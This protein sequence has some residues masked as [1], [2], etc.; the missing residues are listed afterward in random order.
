M[1]FVSKTSFSSLNDLYRTTDFFYKGSSGSVL[2]S[3]VSTPNDD[4]VKEAIEKYKLEKTNAVN[5]TESLNWYID[6]IGIAISDTQTFFGE[7]PSALGG[8]ISQLQ[9]LQSVLQEMKRHFSD[10]ETSTCAEKVFIVEQQHKWISAQ[11]TGVAATARGGFTDIP[12]EERVTAAE[13]LVTDVGIDTGSDISLLTLPRDFKEQC[14]FLS[15]IFQ[16]TEFHRD[17]QGGALSESTVD[18]T[19]VEARMSINAI[20]GAGTGNAENITLKNLPYAADRDWEIP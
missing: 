13:N 11:E 16:F 8:Q 7:E 3:Q 14:I 12:L 4:D 6:T 18:V 2:P 17:F 15:Q 20:Q 1:S 9:E 19:D 10:Q 5:N